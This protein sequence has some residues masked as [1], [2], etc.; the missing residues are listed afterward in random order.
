MRTPS[1]LYAN[2][3]LMKEYGIKEDQICNIEDLFKLADMV[4]YRKENVEGAFSESVTLV[5][6]TMLHSKE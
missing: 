1:A 3:K 5:L 4:R 6:F 2:T